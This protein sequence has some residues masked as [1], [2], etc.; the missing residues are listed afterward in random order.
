MPI[1]PTYSVITRRPKHPAGTHTL[2]AQ[3]LSSA[4]QKPGQRCPLGAL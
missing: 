2:G 3:P 4:R 1:Y